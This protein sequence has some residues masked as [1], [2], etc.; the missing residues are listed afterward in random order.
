MRDSVRKFLIDAG[1]GLGL[2][3]LV[4]VIQGLFKAGTEADVL[5]I[6]CDGFFTAAMLLLAAGGLQW[7]CN[8]GVLDGLGFTF[9]R[10]IARMRRD[11]ETSHMSFAEYRE[12]REKKARTPKYLLLAG[13]C[14]LV[15]ALILFTAYSKAI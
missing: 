6:L 11:F 9:S 2:A 13:A 15:I 8:G 12:K 3:A 7:T 10:G 5:R 1:V 4:C 14:H